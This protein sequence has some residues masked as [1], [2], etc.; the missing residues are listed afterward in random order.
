MAVALGLAQRSLGRVWPN[1]AVGCVIVDRDGR[2][3]GAG[4]TQDGGRP[5]AETE[6]IR[7][8]GARAR[9]GVAYV[10]LEPCAHQGQTGP[11]ASALIASGV[12]RVV[13]A[14][15]DPDPRVSGKGHEMLRAAGIAVTTGI[16]HAAATQLNGGFLSRVR[17]GR[18]LVTLKLATTLDGRI[19]LPSGQSQWITG[20]QAR[21]HAHLV[22]SQHDAVLVGIGTVLADDP[23]LTCR[24]PGVHHPRLVR[25]VADT[26]AKL[27]EA[28]RLVQGAGRSPVWLLTA[29][30]DNA[31]RLARHNV[32]ILPVAAGPE[33]IDLPQAMALLAG[34]GLTR[35][36]VEGGSRL[37]ASLL[38]LNLADR[39]VWYRA[40][41]IMGEGVPAF[42]GTTLARL[43]D[44]PRVLRKE[45]RQLGQD[46]L[47]T[48]EFGT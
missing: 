33:G 5:H 11:C 16:L 37:H 20:H 3:A 45:T 22:R 23:E 46:V 47:E 48:Y 21:A 29:R 27:P 24:L 41:A 7:Q 8:A 35:L 28:S 12:A 2:M 17:R 31:A 25:V 44:M 13:S 15:E 39:I 42:C 19:A 38:R 30:P 32:R 6:A 34:E 36:M 40:S 4:W 10:S 43:D 18:P 14:I 9:G 1:P 26:Q